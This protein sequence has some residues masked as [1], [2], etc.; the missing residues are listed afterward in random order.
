VGCSKTRAVMN[1]LAESL[2]LLP[3]E[4]MSAKSPNPRVFIEAL[5]N[6]E[7]CTPDFVH[8]TF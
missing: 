5:P 4:I 7:A 8:S 6:N 3:R 2:T 1:E